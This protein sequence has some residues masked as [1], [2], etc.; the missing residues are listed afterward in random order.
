[1]VFL[2]ACS[3]SFTTAPKT[4]ADDFKSYVLGCQFISLFIEIKHSLPKTKC[5]RIIFTYFLTPFRFYCGIILQH[6]LIFLMPSYIQ[7]IKIK[8]TKIFIKV[9]YYY[10]YLY[11]YFKP[12]LFFGRRGWG[13]GMKNYLKLK[14]A[15]QIIKVKIY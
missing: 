15:M 7:I 1:M 12:F 6:R 9:F 13:G 10:Y 4:K 2:S 8:N 3:I 14:I 11:A 5:N